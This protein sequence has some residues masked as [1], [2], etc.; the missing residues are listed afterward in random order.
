MISKRNLI[1]AILTLFL[2]LIFCG[3]ASATWN[4]TTV[5]TTNNTGQYTSIALDTNNYPHISYYESTNGNLKYARWNGTAWEITTVD[6]TGDVG[7]YTSIALDTNNYPHISYYR[8]GFLTGDLKYARWNGTAW[9]I[10][11]VD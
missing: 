5:D 6:S 3:S 7:L 11:T 2:A 9:E 4:I 1:M 10:T 8:G